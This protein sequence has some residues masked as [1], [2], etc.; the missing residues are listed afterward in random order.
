MFKIEYSTPKG[1]RWCVEC[2]DID[3]ARRVASTSLN[4]IVGIFHKGKRVVYSRLVVD[5]RIVYVD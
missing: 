1:I 2:T 4:P 5:R 3:D